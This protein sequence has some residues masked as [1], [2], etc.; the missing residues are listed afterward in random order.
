MPLTTTTKLGIFGIWQKRFLVF[1]LSIGMALLLSNRSISYVAKPTKILWDIY[2]IPHIYGAHPQDAFRAFGWAQMQS[3][4]NLLLRL[5]GQ[6]R[7]KA[8]QYWGEEYLDSDKMGIN[9]ERTQKRQ[10]LVPSPKPGFS[11]LRGRFCQRN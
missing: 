10:R 9:N 4:G 6:A 5:Y 8:A 7:F 3:H 1:L 11:Q 2:G